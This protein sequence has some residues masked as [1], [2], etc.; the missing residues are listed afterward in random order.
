MPGSKRT[1]DSKEI[2][3]KKLG[4]KIY[5][6]V[7]KRMQV[8][9]TPA[10]SISLF[11]GNRMVYS[12]GFGNRDMAGLLPADEKTLYGVG[13]VTKSFTAL[14]I[15][16]LMEKGLLDVH[17]R[18][19]RFLP[20]FGSDSP[21]G[22]VEI[23]HLLNHTSGLPTLNVAEITL[24][25]E[26]GDDTSFIPLAGYGDFV[27]IILSSADERVAPPGKKF[28][29]WNEGYT[30]LGRIIE[31]LSG[32]SYIDCIRKQILGPLEMRRSGFG[33]EAMGI[34]GN[35]ATLY[36]YS[37]DGKHKQ[38]LLRS[39]TSDV[40]A[41]GL[42]SST[43]ELCNYLRF[44][45]SGGTYKGR[46]LISHKLLNEATTRGVKAGED[47]QFGSPVYGY[48]WMIA[49]NF[50]GHRL[51]SHSGDVGISSSYVGFIPDLDIGVAVASNI[52]DGPNSNV[53]VYALATLAGVD[54][55]SALDYV[56]V[57]N[58][59]DELIGVYS[60]F[61]GYTTLTVSAWGPGYLKGEYRSNEM[62]F[63][64][65]LMFD[66]RSLYTISNY[67]R[68]PVDWRVLPDGRKELLLERHRF[69]KK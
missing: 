6:Y 16:Q 15:L 32:A 17:D 47:S 7:S 62:T 39:Q 55:D 56:A 46:S 22:D 23:F 11:S 41:G 34:D 1:S 43:E 67:S 28:L 40:A 33:Q 29:Y 9:K 52:G 53:G 51:V 42:V 65:P 30:I 49:D 3:E 45:I 68:T 54:A 18:I 13:S 8:T 35:A 5:R 24:M 66:R 50:F 38:A 48:G 4:D 63:S 10:M 31:K 21:L 61:R 12:R 58:M 69:V 36:K 27:D 57:Q 14:A 64:M 20:E 2:G 25:R 37:E 19:S 26:F 59:S 60:D 44:M